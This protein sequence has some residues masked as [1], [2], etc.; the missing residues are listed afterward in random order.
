MGTSP[1]RYGH[2]M[3][4]QG[5]GCGSI[6]QPPG[7]ATL[8]AECGGRASRPT[9]KARRSLVPL[10]AAEGL[11]DHLGPER[12]TR[13]RWLV[14]AQASPCSAGAGRNGRKG[15]SLSYESRWPPW[16]TTNPP[17]TGP[18]FLWSQGP[19]L[20]PQKKKW[21]LPLRRGAAPPEGLRPLAGSQPP[22]GSRPQLYHFA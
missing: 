6:R 10:C 12:G 9:K 21:T 14:R 4:E 5:R 2:A 13:R 3:V 19:F 16:T 17:K 11:P 18:L 22:A 15:S 8:A 20:F 7:C 1:G